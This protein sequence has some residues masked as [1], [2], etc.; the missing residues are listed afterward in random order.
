MAEVLTRVAETFVLQNDYEK[1]LKAAESATSLATQLDN[2]DLLWYAQ[3]LAGNAQAKLDH[4]PQAY[5]SLTSAIAT[6]ESLR[7]EAS[8]VAGDHRRLLP[9]L[10]MIDFLMGQ[11]RP[12]ET[13]HYAERAK[14]QFLIDLLKSNNA[15]TSKGLS[16]EQRREE[17]RLLS[18]V[19]SLEIQLGREAEQRLPSETR[20]L[21][22]RE[23]LRRARAAYAAFCRKAFSENPA[24]K[25]GR[26]ESLSRVRIPPPPPLAMS[27]MFDTN[28]F[29]S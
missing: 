12:S 13:F 29:S 28:T 10:A 1:A 4:G 26:G 24:L 16:P 9:Y 3:M 21:D 25:T 27:K 20:R 19:A 7:A 8:V 18:E 11:H 5:N 22:V 14:T 23:K 15:T 17:Q 2:K 6:V